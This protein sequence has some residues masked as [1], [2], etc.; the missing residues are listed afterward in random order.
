MSLMIRE[1]QINATVRH[2]F[3]C[4]RMAITKKKRA[5]DDEDVKTLNKSYIAVVGDV[6]WSNH[7]AKQSRSFSKD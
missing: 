1:M 3:I 2:H 6:K 5:S 7:C 4:V